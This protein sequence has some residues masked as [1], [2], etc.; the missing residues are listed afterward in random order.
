MYDLSHSD[1][2]L[3]V[4]IIAALKISMVVILCIVLFGGDPDIVDS[5][6]MLIR[7]FSGKG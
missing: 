2:D 5:L 7:S 6:G 1:F 3:L 4:F